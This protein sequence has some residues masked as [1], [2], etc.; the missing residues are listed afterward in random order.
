M[1]LCVGWLGEGAWAT[2][3]R[4]WGVALEVGEA[5][6]QAQEIPD[7]ARR[8]DDISKS[9]ISTSRPNTEINNHNYGPIRPFFNDR[10]VGSR[11][12]SDCT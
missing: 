2:G 5:C 1:R 6:Y 12:M 10:P 3:D 11:H 4:C 8:V 9:T 7:K